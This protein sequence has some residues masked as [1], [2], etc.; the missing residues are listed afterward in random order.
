MLVVSVAQAQ[1]R[2]VRQTLPLVGSVKPY[3]RS[4]IASEVSGLVKELRVEQGDRVEAGMTICKLRDT[5]RRMIYSEAEALLKQLEAELE[6]LEAGTR[7]EEIEEARAAMEE[8]KAVYKKWE[9]ELLRITRHREDGVA[10]PKEYNDTI[11]DHAAA[12]ERLAKTK[13]SYELA[14]AGPR[15]E[16]IARARYAVEARKAVVA[17]LKYNLDQTVICAPFAGYVTEKHAEVGEWLNVGGAVVELIDLDRVLVKVDVPES[18]ISSVSVG[19]SVAVVVDALNKTWRGKVKHVI[20]QADEKARTFPIEIELDNRS[21]ELKSG[22]FIRA[23]MPAGPTTESVIVPRDAVI[24][25]DNTYYVVM[26]GP[27]QAPLESEMAIP[28]PVGLGADVGD[29]IVVN[30]PAIQ[31]GMKVAVKGHD[32]IYGPLPVKSLPGEVRAPVTI[33]A[34]TKPAADKVGRNITTS[35][36]AK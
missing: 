1:K 7:K 35:N 18:A 33:G 19:D 32:R 29:W 4:L 31:S 2:M 28:I 25:R 34:T 11:T 10:S 5:T 30:S 23:R 16:K 20:P 6:E 3:T 36:P 26:V 9:M 22:M 24:Q 13:A 12:R 17:L 27:A 14:V 15:A 8:A 21:Y